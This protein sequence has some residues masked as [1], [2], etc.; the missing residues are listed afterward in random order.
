[1]PRTIALIVTDPDAGRLGH[2]RRVDDMLAGRSV[3][4]HTAARAARIER[5]ERVVVVHPPGRD[6]LAAVGVEAIGKPVSGF[7]HDDAG[8][9][10]A[11]A[12]ARKWAM[13]GWRGGI[14]GAT[15]WDELLPAKALAAAAEQHGADAVVLVGGDWCL[16]DVGYADELLALHLDAPDAMRVT[17]TQAPPGLG[18]VVLGAGTLRDLADGGATIGAVLAYRPTRPAIDPIG[19]ECNHP[20]PA[21]VRDT[22]RR[23][24][25]DTPDGVR[26]LERLAKSL[27]ASFATA[28]ALAVTDA[29]RAYELDH[30]DHVFDELPDQVVI[31]LTPRRLAD[32][33]ITAQRYVDLG[34]GDMDVSLAK[35]VL[36]Q[37]GGRA[38]TFGGVGDPTLHP[39]WRELV[40]AA[41]DAGV[42]GL[43]VETDLLGEPE[44]LW[45]LVEN[46]RGDVVSVRLNADT[47]ATYA[48]VMGVD[49][50]GEVMQRLQGLFDRRDGHGS[51]WIVPRLVKTAET[52][53][54]MESFFDRWMHLVGHAVIDRPPTFGTGS[55]ALAPDRSPVPMDPP[56][57][58][59]SPWQVKRRMTVLSD[60]TATLCA[61]DV[62]GRA[63]LGSV[64][65][66][67]LWD[68][69]RIAAELELPGGGLDDSP[70]CRRC[71][72]WLSLHGRAATVGAVV[73]PI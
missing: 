37:C 52:L 15:A 25:Y 53:P 59:P 40:D 71:F 72:D 70:V 5:V 32:G 68:L 17:F 35:D 73:G 44:T 67:P 51:P 42:L 47:A 64:S 43:H 3:L 38:V 45:P 46:F 56:W 50:F 57:R 19:R 39:A 21:T 11:I 34:R 41:A 9:S 55:Y 62:L 65:E 54:D 28:D 1:M 4:H 22:A 13:S 29:C 60:G 30:P 2:S 16:F 26:R 27:G 14:N 36:A 58:E 6:L 7:V 66:R 49:R 69:W 48:K 12:S 18:P 10:A 20:I 33:P 8:P 61:E 23:F 31:E 63:A 24:V